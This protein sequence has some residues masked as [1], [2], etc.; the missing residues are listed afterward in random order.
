MAADLLCPGV[1]ERRR[2]RDSSRREPLSRQ[3][4]SGWAPQHGDVWRCWS[5]GVGNSSRGSTAIIVYY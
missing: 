1:R 4:G 3:C 5:L 2:S